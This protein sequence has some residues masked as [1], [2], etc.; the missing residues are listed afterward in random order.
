MSVVPPEIAALAP[1]LEANVTGL[2]RCEGFEKFGDG[3]SNPT[4]RIDASGGT[5]V[6]RAQPP[7][8]LLKG[9]HRVDR[10]AR[11]IDALGATAVPVPRILATSDAE[12]PLGRMF[13][14]M[15]HVAGNIYWDPALPELSNPA[16]TA[17][18]EAMNATLA[19]LHDVDPG[20]VGLSDF[21]RAG[22]YFERQ[23]ATWTRQYRASETES[24]AA[25]DR[26]IAWLEE[27]LP[28]D[29]GRSG[30]VHGDFRLDNMIFDPDTHEVAA[31]LDW[32]LSTLGHPFADLAYQC[33]QWRLPNE[34][35]FKGLGGVDRAASGIPTEEA[36]VA[37]YCE[38]RGLPEIGNWPFYIAFSFFR[39]AA[40]LQGVYRRSLDG[41]ASNAQT[42]QLYG[43]AVPT[44]A[45]LAMEEVGAP[46]PRRL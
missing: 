35:A 29:D 42:G 23:L 44:L 19:A 46:V 34:G 17:V 9:A 14:V 25:M 26:L 32:E 22:D 13:V 8:K 12:G 45:Q 33:M 28:A 31:V 38:R 40:I 3:Q 10:E 11:V 30:L 27:N 43:K 1:W 20:A 7:G 39:L 41:N 37:R 36:Y 24:I 21:G 4:Y 15:S 2:G 16:R 5:F 18:Y 6:L